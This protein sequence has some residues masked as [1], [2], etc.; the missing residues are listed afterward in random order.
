M[1]TDPLVWL[2]AGI[3]LG[4]AGVLLFLVAAWLTYVS[5]G[6]LPWD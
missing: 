4:V 5:G 3:S 1:A 6:R 2:V